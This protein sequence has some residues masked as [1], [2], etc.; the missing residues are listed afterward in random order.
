VQRQFNETKDSV[1]E[2]SGVKELESTLRKANK[3]INSS[4]QK[5]MKDAAK[6]VVTGSGAAATQDASAAA[7]AS[8]DDIEDA[9]IVEPTDAAK[10]ADDADAPEEGDTNIT[11][12]FA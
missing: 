3:V 8:D 1:V 10:S 7:A 9:E 12:D 4:P 5:M 11:V 6:N 2:A